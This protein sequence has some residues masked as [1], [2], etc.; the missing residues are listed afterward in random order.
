MTIIIDDAGSGD[1]LLG[2]VI[3]A[4]RPDPLDFTYDMI[5]VHYFQPPQFARKAYLQQ[6]S[7]IVFA[8]LRRLQRQADEA[9]QICR[10]YLFDQAVDDMIHT[11]GADHVHRVIVE[12]EAQRLTETAYLDELRNLGYHPL[13]HRETR[14]AKSFFHMLHWLKTHPDKLK[15]A[16]T[17]WPR[18]TRYP[19]FR[20]LLR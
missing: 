5:E 16:K 6:A 11:Y 19:E 15:Y 17:G 7:R 13:T 1:L 3:G 4:Y 8:L 9:I 2:V 12:G 20:A 18:L 14:R 10:S